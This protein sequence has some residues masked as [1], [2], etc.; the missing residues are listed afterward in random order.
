M[1]DEQ[2]T[3]APA[4]S[5]IQAE[6][7]RIR[8]VPGDPVIAVEED[9]AKGMY[10]VEVKARTIPAVT[11]A[12]RDDPKLDYK[13]LC[14]LFAYDRPWEEKRFSV[15]YNLYSITHNRRIFLRVRAAEGEAVPSLSGVFAA[16]EP[17]EREVY[18]LLGVTFSGHPNLTRIMM[19]DD[20]KGHP[21]RK[22]YPPVG[23]RPVI[24]YNDVKD[25]L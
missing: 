4:A 15:V 17:A 1:A 5:P 22:D 9:A 16:A 12:L 2:Q 18:D 8:S 10:W 21:L 24:L 11:A 6:L 3:A 7:A 19:P 20:W 23:R 13:L 25:V 14:D